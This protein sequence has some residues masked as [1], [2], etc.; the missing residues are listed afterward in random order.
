MLGLA[1]LLPLATSAASGSLLH[2]RRP[3]EQAKSGAHHSPRQAPGIDPNWDPQAQPD[4]HLNPDWSPDPDNVEPISL[5]GGISPWDD[6]GRS[7]M[8]D[9]QPLW[10]N[11][12]A[13]YL[14]CHKCPR[15]FRCHLSS[16]STSVPSATRTPHSKPPQGEEFNALTGPQLV[17][18][19]NLGGKKE[20]CPLRKCGGKAGTECGPGARCSK[21]YC[22]CPAGYKGDSGN[23]LRGR[24]RPEA[25]TVYVDPGIACD[26]PCQV[27]FCPEVER[28]RGCFG[29]EALAGQPSATTPASGIAQSTPS[30]GAAGH[31]EPESQGIAGGHGVIQFPG[32]VPQEGSDYV[33]GI[34][35]S[36]GIR[37]NVMH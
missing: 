19:G 1:V 2:D 30:M 6:S 34:A 35:D 33:A 25:L 5:D 29:V 11:C 16:S 26:T 10:V 18:F 17:G 15:D 20:Q 9:F 13:R 4:F 8:M 14:N 32:V 28:V 37:E 36:G 24:S 22:A 7:Q 23:A 21:G 12:P 3:H 27:L 31:E